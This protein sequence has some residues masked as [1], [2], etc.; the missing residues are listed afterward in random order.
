MLNE[1][2]IASLKKIELSENRGSGINYL[3]IFTCRGN[4]PSVKIARILGIEF[5]RRIAQPNDPDHLNKMI[6]LF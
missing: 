6:T 1:R 5:V 3:Q 4:L 2:S